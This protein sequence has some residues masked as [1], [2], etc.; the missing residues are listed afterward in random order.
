M[1]KNET[2]PDLITYLENYQEWRRGADIEQPNPTELG[3]KLD[4]AIQYLKLILG[5]G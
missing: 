3:Q 2:E 4:E 5:H 1:S